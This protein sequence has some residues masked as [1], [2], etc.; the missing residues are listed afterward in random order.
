MAAE[1]RR[2]GVAPELSEAGDGVDVA[3]GSTIAEYLDQQVLAVGFDAGVLVT[4]K[5]DKLALEF[6]GL[7]ECVWRWHGV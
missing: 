2:V 4:G 3:V 7:C 6:S 1:G 5:R